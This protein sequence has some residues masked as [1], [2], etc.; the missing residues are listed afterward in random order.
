MTMLTA[1]R[2]LRLVKEV[3]RR[4]LSRVVGAF[5]RLLTPQRNVRVY[6]CGNEPLW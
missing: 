1:Q 3:G 5:T 4:R 6:E 2:I